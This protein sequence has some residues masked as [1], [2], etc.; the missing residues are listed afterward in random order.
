MIQS[1]WVEVLG[2]GERQLRAKLGG[3]A[4]EDPEWDPDVLVAQMAAAMGR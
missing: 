2:L 4:A 3:I 1:W